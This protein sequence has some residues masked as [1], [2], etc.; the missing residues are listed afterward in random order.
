VKR[1]LADSKDALEL[2]TGNRIRC[3]AL[4]YGSSSPEVIRTAQEVGYEYVF[5]NVPVF[6]DVAT[7]CQL[8]GRVDT[9]PR[10]WPLEFYLKLHGAYEWMAVA[11][12]AKRQ[13]LNT[14]R[15]STES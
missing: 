1:E 9:S 13:L 2:L 11:V 15:V 12:P 3:L 10:D 4:P 5:A 7:P 6:S 8:V 14:V